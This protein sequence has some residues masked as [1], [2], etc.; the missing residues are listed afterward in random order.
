MT[1][2]AI[3]WGFASSNQWTSFKYLGLPIFKKNPSGKDWIPLIDKFKN[4]LQAWGLSWLNIAGKT[5][6]IKSVLN[7]LPIYQASLMLAPPGIIRKLEGL[8][9]KFFWK[10][11][12][13]NSKRFPLVSWDKV[14]KPILEGG[15]N[16]KDLRLQSIALGA[17]IQILKLCMQAQEI[18]KDHLFWIQGNGKSI[19]LWEDRIMNDAPL[20]DSHDLKELC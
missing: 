4:K 6:L 18:I 10:G 16:L 14:S 1:S 15:L 20:V 5:V 13:Q 12:K 17:R 11:G 9:R 3:C 2:I 8:T 19:N 7:N